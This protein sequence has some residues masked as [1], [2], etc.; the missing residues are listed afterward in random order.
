[1]IL[2]YVVYLAHT[3]QILQIPAQ[4]VQ[5]LLE[6]LILLPFGFEWLIPLP[7]MDSIRDSPRCMQ[8]PDWLEQRSMPA[9][10]RS[11]LQAHKTMCSIFFL[12][13]RKLMP[14]LWNALVSRPD[15]RLSKVED[16]VDGFFLSHQN[17]HNERAL[18]IRLRHVTG[19]RLPLAG[20]FGSAIRW[21]SQD[22]KSLE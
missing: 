22:V 17:L 9:V 10:E 16:D 13:D 19:C 14:V 21:P 3:T 5:A 2:C 18:P 11:R 8:H 6:R 20:G 7:Q 1:M 15:Q 12:S 4:N